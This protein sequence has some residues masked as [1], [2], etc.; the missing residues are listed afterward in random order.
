MELE[1]VIIKYKQVIQFK[2]RKCC[3]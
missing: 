3:C 1:F 2:Q